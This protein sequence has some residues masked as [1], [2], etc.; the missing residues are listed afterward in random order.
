MIRHALVVAALLGAATAAPAA[1]DRPAPGETTISRMSQFL[2][3]QPDGASALYIRGENGRWY[4]VRL[5]TD[6]PR[7]LNRSNV[8]FDSSPS[9]RFD[10]YSSIRA[11][12]WR[13][14][15]ASITASAGPPPHRHAR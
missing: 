3:W 7:L 6:C 8:H 2:D 12:G 10:R 13:C 4:Y 5:Q 14:Q 1:M 15:V 9:D 11:D